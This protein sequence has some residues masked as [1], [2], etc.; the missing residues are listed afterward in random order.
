MHVF[1]LFRN[2]NSIP[3]VHMD[4]V[5]FSLPAEAMVRIA[6]S[7]A[8]M[9]SHLDI[10]VLDD[11]ISL[12]VT[13]LSSFETSLLFARQLEFA[14]PPLFLVSILRHSHPFRL[15][16]MDPRT[17]EEGRKTLPD[18]EAEAAAASGTSDNP[19]ETTP[20]Q[21]PQSSSSPTAAAAEGRGG[22][23]RGG[24]ASKTGKTINFADEKAAL[25]AEDKE[26]TAPGDASAGKKDDQGENAA[27]VK[28]EGNDKVIDINEEKPSAFPPLNDIPVE[29]LYDHDKYNLS[30]MDPTDVFQILQ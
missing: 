5:L 27:A 25:S 11:T 29:T 7:L 17:A 16:G 6:G 9:H 10:Y 15:D 24:Q 4:G 18:K 12:C 20:Q 2:S 21:A 13:A 3:Y 19:N 23:T 8:F 14:F 26:N 1:V 30:T 28:Q 22:G